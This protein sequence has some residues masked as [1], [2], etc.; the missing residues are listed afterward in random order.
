ML[1]KE[2]LEFIKNKDLKDV[3]SDCQIDYGTYQ[4]RAYGVKE[5]NEI[6]KM[7][8]DDETLGLY[9]YTQHLYIPEWQQLERYLSKPNIAE[10]CEFKI[11]GIVIRRKDGTGSMDMVFTCMK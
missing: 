5:N 1:T 8:L 11:Q 2:E 7:N 6:T 9:G 3:V 4:F 10:N